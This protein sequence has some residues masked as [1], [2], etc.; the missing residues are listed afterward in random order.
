M[1]TFLPAAVTGSKAEKAIKPAETLPDAWL[2]SAKK[3]EAWYLSDI[4]AIATKDQQDKF[5]FPKEDLS[6]M[7]KMDQFITYSLMAI[8]ICLMAGFLTPLAALGGIGFLL[9]VTFSQPP[10]L[11]NI[12]KTTYFEYT[13]IFALLVLVVTCAGRFGGLDFFI[14]RIWNCCRGAKGGTK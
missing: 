5:G 11:P 4:H 13:E 2:D 9:S 3:L 14:G 8:G 6:A 7:K 1:L 10:W 12:V